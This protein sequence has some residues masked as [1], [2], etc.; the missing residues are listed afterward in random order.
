MSKMSRNHRQATNGHRPQAFSLLEIVVSLL[1]LTVLASLAIPTLQA[2]SSTAKSAVAQADAVGVGHDIQ[3]LAKTGQFTSISQIT[4]ETSATVVQSATSSSRVFFDVT[5]TNGSKACLSMPTSYASQTVTSGT[6]TAATTPVVTSVVNQGN[7]SSSPA[8]ASCWGNSYVTITGTGFTYAT[9]VLLAT[10]PSFIASYTIDS[11]T[12]ITAKIAN[13]S[14]VF[15]GV[16]DIQVTTPFSTSTT[17]AADQ[18]SSTLGVFAQQNTTASNSASASSS[19]STT[20]TLPYPVSAGDALFATISYTSDSISGTVTVTPPTGWKPSP[21]NNNNLGSA[22]WGSFST[23]G[24]Y[25]VPVTAATSSAPSYTFTVTLS[26]SSPAQLNLAVGL[27]ELHLD[28]NVTLSKCNSGACTAA[29]Y[30]SANAVSSMGYWLTAAYTSGTALSVINATAFAPGM[31]I[32]VGSDTGTVATVNY[33][34]GAVTLTASLPNAHPSGEWVTTSGSTMALGY[35]NVNPFYAGQVCTAGLVVNSVGGTG[36]ITSFNAV[37][38]NVTLVKVTGG[39]A[40][41]EM[42]ISWTNTASSLATRPTWAAPGIGVAE[43]IEIDYPYC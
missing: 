16:Y 41:L 29:P 42:Y 2:V 20:V 36:A 14:G 17:T 18:V 15:C 28:N 27:S 25:Y 19:V 40:S 12:Q 37:S 3:T 11:P 22:S 38:G 7:G 30:N 43:G 8:T 9:S 35:T 34:T 32:V 5:A 23:T 31:T 4:S 13:L 1:V 26:G 33:G 24:Q 10:I 39:P 6:C 21:T